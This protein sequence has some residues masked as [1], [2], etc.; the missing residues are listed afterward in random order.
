MPEFDKISALETWS[1]IL[2]TLSAIL[3]ITT[4]ILFIDTKKIPERI[5]NW[6]KKRSVLR[7]NRQG[8]TSTAD[9]NAKKHT[10]SNLTADPPTTFLKKAPDG[11]FKV[12]KRIILS[13]RGIV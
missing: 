13:E 4:I 8:E 5:R 2:L 1:V 3:F 10:V 12:I 6:L 11:D 7:R 9:L